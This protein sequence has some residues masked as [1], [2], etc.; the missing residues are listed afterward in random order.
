NTGHE[1]SLATVHANTPRDAL[2]R[3][4]A[5][6]LM[7][8]AELPVWALREMIASAVHMVVQLTR[9]S[10]GSRKVTAVSEITGREENQ[11]LTHDL[12]KYKQTGINSAGKVVG[13]F[14]AMGEPP[15][16]YGDFK[17]SGLDMP[18]DLFWTPEQKAERSRK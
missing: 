10:D 6:C 9:F 12:F 17:T 13:E 4:E 8:G 15:K 3:L 11:I 14:R 5:M 2:T 16:F 7:A 1:G 18:I